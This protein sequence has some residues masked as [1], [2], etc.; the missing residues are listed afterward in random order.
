M[1]KIY[2]LASLFLASGFAFSQTPALEAEVHELAT[3]IVEKRISFEVA[4]RAPGDIIWV[5]SF[6]V[7]SNWLAGG[8]TPDSSVHGWSIADFTGGWAFNDT[9]DMNT[10]GTF[11][12]FVNGEDDAADAIA[13]PFTF[14][15]V[16]G[17][18]NG[19]IDLTGV[20]APHLEFEQY[21]ARFITVQSVEISTDGGA[22]WFQAAL[23]DDAPLTAN[24]GSAYARPETK[25][26]NLVPTLQAAGGSLA[27]V[28]VRLFWDGDMNGA[29]INYIDYGWFVDNIRIVEGEEYESEIRNATY[30][31]G[32]NG[33]VWAPGLS[34]HQ[35]PLHQVSEVEFSAEIFNNGS[36]LATG[37]NV[38]ANISGTETWTANSPSRD[39]GPSM[40]DSFV[41]SSTFLPTAGFGTYNIEI[42]ADQTNIDADS[43]N[44]SFITSFEIGESV[45]A[46]DNGIAEGGIGNFAS[47]AGQPFS[48]GNTMEVFAD[49]IV[50]DMEI[51]LT[52]D[53]TNIG[54]VMFGTI[55]RAEAGA[56]VQVAVTENYTITAN[57]ILGAP[58]KIPMRNGVAFDVS[59]GD[60]LLVMGAH[61]G[62]TDPVR[63][64]SAQ[65]VEERT[66]LGVRSDN[67][68]GFLGDPNIVMVRLIMPWNVSVEESENSVINVAQNVPNPFSNNTLI[69]YTLT[70]TAN[71][72]LT[73]VDLAGKVVATYNE[74]T[75]GAGEHNI[76]VGANQLSD[77]VYF[78]NFKAGD[79][80][81]TK[82]MVVNK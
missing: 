50:T 58:V 5:D 31:W 26:F 10:Q 41:V 57:D 77:G 4:D 28:Q 30:R 25:R 7:A 62:G 63:F 24:G 18:N 45:Y 21:G 48:I 67:S 70:E 33:N 54:Q 47:N 59:A 15:Y 65:K 32:V 71:V 66:V 72:S 23:N 73:V 3:E 74:G 61:F 37:S 55:Y 20:P 51:V 44:D 36:L 49:G 80:S 34:Y 38:V 22:N 35:I 17:P 2:L 29:N 14:E 13:G 11:A 40:V 39:I 19:L 56:Y 79:Y 68:L 42:L 9:L 52:D 1:K 76:T 16:G 64:A 43:T 12:R 60:D 6:E 8:T 82:R 53:S 46:R 81:V 69:N 75:R 27:N 78:Y